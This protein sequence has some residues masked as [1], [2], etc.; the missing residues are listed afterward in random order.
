VTQPD[1]LK[2]GDRVEHVDP[3]ETETWESAV[4][5]VPRYDAWDDRALVGIKYAR[6]RGHGTQLVRADH[7][8]P[9]RNA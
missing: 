5:V 2:I 8:L 7:L 6:S 4:V 3:R 1:S 9:R